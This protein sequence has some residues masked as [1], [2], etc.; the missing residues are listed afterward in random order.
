MLPLLGVRVA[1]AVLLPQAA[2]ATLDLQRLDTYS[3]AWADS[4]AGSRLEEQARRDFG[5]RGVEIANH[6][7]IHTDP[8]PRNDA[9][10]FVLR[11]VG[12]ADTALALIRALPQPPTHESGILDRHFG[13]IAAAIEAVLAN[14][15]PRRDPRIVAALAQSISIARAKPAGSGRHEALEGVRL[16][17]MCRSVEAARALAR[18]ATDPDAEI[19]TAA[20]GALGHLEPAAPAA[21][22]DPTPAPAQDLLRL[23]VT[24]S[25]PSARR[26]A[27]DALGAIEGA[28]IDARLR[29]A[30]DAERDPRVVDGIVQA[31]RR[32]G[33]PVDDPG[34]CR[35]L[36]GRAWEAAIAQQLLDCW[37]RPGI[38]REALVQAAI[39]GPA[40]QRA[41]ALFTV[42]MPVLRE[43][44]RSLVVDRSGQTRVFDAPVRERLLESAVWV[45]SQ[46]EA[47][48]A[49]TRDTTEQALWELSG[50]SMDMATTYAD[51]VTPNTARFRASAALARAD[52]PAYDATRRRRQVVIALA[53][54]IAFGLFVVRRSPL[55]RPALLLTLSA[56]GWAL[57]T[58]RASGVRDLPPPPLQLLSVAALAFLSAGMA[59][60]IAT[61]IPRRAP[62]VAAK[63]IRFVL[64][65]I[66]AAGVAGVICF[67]TRSARLF[68]GDREGWELIFDPLGA[69]ILAAAAAAVLMAI[70]GG[71]H[72]GFV[73]ARD[74]RG[75]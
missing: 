41:V 65:S 28:A 29:A 31:L 24:D 72:A 63:I 8:R 68:P 42:T 7:L 10:F 27:A 19:R 59:T 14:D 40:T 4:V 53:I 64:V 69:A 33:T 46:G 71:A 67:A 75:A 44:A 21:A 73:D 3:S 57:W 36:I 2:S 20:A 56:I 26:Q 45:L 32:R 58:F 49:S 62:N 37:L 74:A 51:R 55:Q 61:L 50:R 70:E 43:S 5:G 12:D 22:A 6:F 48:S 30:L 1:I 47:I 25:S 35:D 17:G 52:T 13:E 15:V 54:A 60:S 18:F 34:Q 9:F 66:A 38:S 11:A 16:I 39:E 23:L